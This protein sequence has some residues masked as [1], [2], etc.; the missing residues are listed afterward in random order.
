MPRTVLVRGILTRSRTMR[1][2]FDLRCMTPDLPTPERPTGFARRPERTTGLE[3]EKDAGPK[4]IADR[5]R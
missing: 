3:E 1:G 2:F 4:F 5:E